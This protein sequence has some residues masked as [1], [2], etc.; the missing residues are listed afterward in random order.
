MVAAEVF[1]DQLPTVIAYAELLCGPGAVRG[2]IGP[3][4]TERIW[5]R[6]VLNCAALAPFMPADASVVDMGS[7]GGLPG[8]V[9]ALARP[10]LT[11]T[12]VDSMARRTEFLTEVV[13]ALG[14]GDRV[15]V[16]RG[17]GE[18][19]KRRDQV[20]TA[21]AV[22]DPLRLARWSTRLLAPKGRLVVLVGASVVADVDGWR[23][24]MQKSGWS[25]V[26][27]ETTDLAGVS[28]S[29]VLRARHR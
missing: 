26:V 23:P 8:V 20:A 21:R 17:R 28:P 13:A 1:G 12:L 5:D 9:L 27:L 18:E 19:L 2:V 4:E 15:T 3:R 14:I 10:D 7:G 16:V 25:D 24:S 22:A 29:Y 11:L 6:H